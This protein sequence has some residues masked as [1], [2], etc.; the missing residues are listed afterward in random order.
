MSARDIRI[1]VDL[2]IDRS[3][4]PQQLPETKNVPFKSF[5]IIAATPGATFDLGAGQG[6]P[7]FPFE[8]GDRWEVDDARCDPPV[9]DGLFIHNTA[10]PGAAIIIH[11]GQSAERGAGNN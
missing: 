8:V 4:L 11:V 1:D 5:T 3:T 7:L 6:A 2:S 10:Q 9:T